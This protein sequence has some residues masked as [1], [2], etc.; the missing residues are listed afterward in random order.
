[1]AWKEAV[2]ALRRTTGVQKDRLR[3]E[4]L[5]GKIPRVD[6]RFRRAKGTDS[7]QLAG[8]SVNP[9]HLSGTP[10]LVR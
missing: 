7:R 2:S 9:R 5:S 4:K 1:M 10:R 6:A 8:R 3:P